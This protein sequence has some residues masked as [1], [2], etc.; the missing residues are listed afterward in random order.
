MNDF[1]LPITGWTAVILGALMLW[2]TFL[3]IFERRTKHIILGEGEDR[4][5]QKRIRGQA[6][7]AEQIP[8][9]LILLGLAEW[10]LPGMVPL[11]IAVIL[12]VGRV[13]HGLYFAY[14][15]LNFRLRVYGMGLTLVAQTLAIL[16]A[17][18]G[19]L[20]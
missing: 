2:L 17:A 20:L 7:A 12:I 8:I 19:L 10:Q 3:V 1:P 14:H 5:T 15:G 13:L 6:N 4:I 16:A 11:S 9:A 18:A